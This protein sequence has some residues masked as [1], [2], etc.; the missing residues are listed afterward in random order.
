VLD[1]DLQLVPQGRSGEICIGG[2]GVG[3]GYW[4]DAELT[5]TRFVS[6][7]CAPGE[8]LYRSGDRGRYGSDGQLEFLGRFDDEVKLHGRRVALGEIELLLRQRTGAEA[9]A[10][11]H[12]AERGAALVGFV[13]AQALTPLSAAALR[14]ELFALLPRHAVPARLVRVKAW[15]RSPNGKLDRDALL[16][17][18]AA[19][20][21]DGV[22]DPLIDRAQQQVAEAIAGV[23]Q[24]DAGTIGAGDDFIALGGDSLHMLAL[25]ERLLRTTGVAFPL[26][27]LMASPSVRELA[28]RADRAAS[29]DE[30]A[31]A[32][33]DLALPLP[34]P[35]PAREQRPWRCVLV[36]GGTGALGQQL[37]AALLGDR[38]LR[39]ISLCR[40]DAD[41]ARARSVRGLTPEQAA[42][43]EIALGDL[44]APLCGLAPAAFAAL[45][46]RVDAIFHLAADTHLGLPYSA[47]RELNVLGTQ[48][49]IELAC[50]GAAGELHYVSS[51]SALFPSYAAIGGRAYERAALAPELLPTGYGQCKAVSEQ[52]VSRAGERG[53]KVRIYR[54]SRIWA[55]GAGSAD[56]LLVRL[57]RGCAE[58]GVFPDCDLRDNVVDT[59]VVARTMVRIAR[60]DDVTQSVFHIVSPHST[61]LSAFVDAL[62]AAGLALSAVSA[63]EFCERMAEAPSLAA[64]RH[65]VSASGLLTTP[66]PVLDLQHTRAVVPD[67]DCPVLDRDQL[68]ARVKHWLEGSI[69]S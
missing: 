35:A 8:R 19:D 43:V 2:A 22:S 34:W 64:L 47:L 29:H 3:A 68:T 7:P 62:R 16:R 15:P 6:H 9:A 48:R 18:A 44:R 30:L 11:V 50:A 61:P 20:R 41:R 4:N 58:L 46:E 69:S 12:T 65:V 1:P 14:R 37:M 10:L 63:D 59:Q 21:G 66:L 53:L 57:V 36:S 38:T 26:P 54:P 67:Y 60:T 27:L 17:L 39:I 52:L 45:A 28:A 51:I 56:D 13:S 32:H 49:M 24:I 5:R 42:R 31:I 23:L 25:S 33:A 55:D 40:G